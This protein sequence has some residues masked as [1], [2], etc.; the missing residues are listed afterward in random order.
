[1][2]TESQSSPWVINTT[3]ALFAADVFERSKVTLVVLDFWAPW[4]GP[5]RALGPTLEKLAESYA[6]RFTLVK[7]NTDE[8]PAAATEFR[9]SGIPAV[10]AVLDGQIIDSFQ[11]AMPEQEIRRWIDHLLT[12][13]QLVEARAQIKADPATAEQTLKAIVAQVPN[14]YEAWILLAELHLSQQRPSE[15]REILAEL[16]NR[17]YLEPAALKLKAQLDLEGKSHGNLDQAQQAALANP[18]DYGLKF[19]YAEALAAH[20]QYEMSF[21]ICLSLVERD[22]K[23]TGEKARELMVNVFRTLPDDSEL[24]RDY[25]RRLSMLLY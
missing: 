3:D 1:M 24:T 21:D 12:K 13:T 4:C 15:A 14:D 23:V 5:C 2:A 19:A 18:D 20:G 11:G 16:E 6:G 10:F 8:T 7:S 22:R 9:V 25:R 17:G